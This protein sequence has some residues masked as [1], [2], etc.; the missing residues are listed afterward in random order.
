[1]IDNL[2]ISYC[3]NYSDKNS[4]KLFEMIILLNIIS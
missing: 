1:M 3:L 4:G 2:N